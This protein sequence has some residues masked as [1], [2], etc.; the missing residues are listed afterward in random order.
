MT[1]GKPRLTLNIRS[2][3]RDKDSSVNLSKAVKK[4]RSNIETMDE[5]WQRIMAMNNSATDQRRIEEVRKA[6][7]GGI[8]G[9]N[10]DE[11]YNARGN[12][13][14]FSKAEALRL[15]SELEK[16]KR[17]KRLKDLVESMPDNY[18]LVLTEEELAESIAVLKREKLIVF[19]VETTGVD[20][21]SDKVVGHVL[22]AT[23]ADIHYYIPTD[24]DDET[25][26]LD[27]EYVACELKNLYATPNIGFIAH[28]AKFDIQMLKNDLN[29]EVVNLTW[30]TLE[31]MKLLNENESS[32]ALKPLATKYLLDNSYTY[33]DLF[34]QVGFDEIDLETSLAY[35][36][37]D[38]D[39]TYRLY[40]FQRRHLEKHGNILG[41]FERVEMPLMP[42]VSEMELNGYHID[43]EHAIAYADDL[44]EKSNKANRRVMKYLGVI[45]RDSQIQLK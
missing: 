34:G 42:I 23:G 32:Y 45:I 9:R 30:D 5:A 1:D 36:A 33:E 44:R 28:N 25:P 8:L 6:M 12:P 14:R 13:K 27:R 24:H 16:G 3:A 38:G 2:P 40:K 35:A 29:I 4:K 39:I 7:E 37:K 18:K 22:S 20:V 31:A 17:V 19:D 11:M 41:Y 15:Y 10:P 26:Q 21:Y 43:E